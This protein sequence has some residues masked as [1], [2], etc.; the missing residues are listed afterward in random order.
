VG[1]VSQN[2]S[3]TKEIKRDTVIGHSATNVNNTVTTAT[4]TQTEMTSA[5]M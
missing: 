4:T 3:P 1:E 5:Q 2:N